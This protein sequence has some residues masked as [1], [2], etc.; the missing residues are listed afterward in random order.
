MNIFRRGNPVY[1]HEVT[2]QEVA[3]RDG[4]QFEK[5]VLPV[6]FR[7]AIINDLVD[8][9]LRKIQVASFVNP[10]KV[11]QMG[12]AENVIAQLPAV[13]GVCYNALVLNTR[14]FERA[15]MAGVRFIEVSVSASDTHSLK[16]AGMN[17]E[18]ALGQATAILSRAREAGIDARGGIQC[19]FGCAIEGPVEVAGVLEM[20][21]RMIDAG[22]DSIALSDTTGMADPVALGNILDQLLP[23]T[24]AI[25][26]ALHLHDTRGLGMVNVAAALEFGITRFDTAAGGMGGCPFT[27]G[28]AGNIATEDTAYLLAALGIE[29]GVDISKVAA[30]SRKLEKAYNKTFPGRV[31]R[32]AE[33]NRRAT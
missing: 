2:L 18:K 10:Q 25:P 30:V 26:V 16:N 24:G 11:P 21:R 4:F 15:Q 7:V 20:V 22:V 6:E 29:T 23:I 1:P 27:P 33:F 8:A 5:F 14:G 9:G 13:D 17:R 28:A 12:G 31:Y 32:L 3:P 19:A